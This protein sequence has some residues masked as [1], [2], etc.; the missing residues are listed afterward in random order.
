MDH[1]PEA[2]QKNAE[3]DAAR[4]AKASRKI[5]VFEVFSFF[6]KPDRLCPGSRRC[7]LSVCFH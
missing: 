5:S 7:R 6:R 1:Q 2:K 3:M 4:K